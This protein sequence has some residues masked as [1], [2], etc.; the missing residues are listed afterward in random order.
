MQPGLPQRPPYLTVG[1]AGGA[2]PAAGAGAGVALAAGAGALFAAGAIDGTTTGTRPVAAGSGLSGMICG[3]VAA[4][5]VFGLTMTGADL[6]LAALLGKA[7]GKVATCFL[8]ALS[9]ASF[10]FWSSGNC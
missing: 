7:L 2:L 1:A 5:P 6:L 4:M 9:A 10:F 8:D 3:L